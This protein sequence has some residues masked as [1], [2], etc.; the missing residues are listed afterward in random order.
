MT[1][2]H[3]RF[4]QWANRPHPLLLAITTA[5]AAAIAVILLLG[6]FDVPIILYKAF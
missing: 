2:L 1:R 4:V 6:K 3:T 5:V